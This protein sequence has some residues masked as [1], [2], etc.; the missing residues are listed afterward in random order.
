M[1]SL[2]SMARGYF[3][4]HQIK[5]AITTIDKLLQ[6]IETMC[7]NISQS[8]SIE[9]P[10]LS[11]I[12]HRYHADILIEKGD[13]VR[14]LQTNKDQSA[15]RMIC[16]IYLEAAELYDSIEA[17]DSSYKTYEMAAKIWMDLANVSPYEI[18]N[19]ISPDH[20]REETLEAAEQASDSWRLS[21]RSADRHINRLDP[22]NTS[23]GIWKA[24]YVI[25]SYH[26][27]ICALRFDYDT[28][29]R[30][31][32]SSE[33]GAKDY[34]SVPHLDEKNRRDMD[35]LLGDIA[36]H[37][38]HC[39]LRLGEYKNAL[40]EMSQCHGQFESLRDDSS[41]DP[42]IYKSR[43]RQIC[44]MKVIA[45]AASHKASEAERELQSLR[46]YYANPSSGKSFEVDIKIDCL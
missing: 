16:S 21:G 45:L 19:V 46:Q 12:I 30:F 38:G 15:I 41:V 36:F 22:S 27:G 7:S 25:S 23:W 6:E 33:A 40:D 37:L 44:S 1:W 42:Q 5:E 24:N 31:F 43:M 18:I 28:A 32:E 9:S 4:S 35:V 17:F 26:A 11:T 34:L 8:D 10:N 29:R 14:R 2:R 3:L 13:Y 20:D 39:Y